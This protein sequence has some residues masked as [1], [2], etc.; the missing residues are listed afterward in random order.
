MLILDA[1]SWVACLPRDHRLADRTE[2]S[3]AELLDDPIVVRAADRRAAGATTGWRWTP[4]ATAADDRRGRRHLRGGDHDDR[5]RSRHQLHHVVGGPVLRPPGH[6]LRAD[7]RPAAAATRRWPGIPRALT[8]QADALIRHVQTH[9]SFGEGSTEHPHSADRPLINPVITRSK[10]GTSAAAPRRLSLCIDYVSY[11]VTS[12]WSD[13]DRRRTRPTHS[14]PP[15]PNDEDAKLAEF[16]YTQKLDRSVG[17]LASFAIG[18]ATISATTAVFTG[19]GAGYFTAGA[20]V[21]V[22]AAARRRGVRAL[23][24]HRRR[25]DRQDPAGRLL[26]SV[27]Q[28]DQRLDAGAGSPAFI[29]LAGW[30]CGMTGVGFI[31]SGYL[32]GLFGWNMTPDRADPRRH[33]R[34]GRLRARSTSTACGSRRW[35][36]TSASASNSSS[37]SAPPSLV[38]IIAFSAPDNHQ[39]ISVLFTGGT[40]GDKDPYILAWLAAVARPV[41]RSHRCG[42][43]RRRRRGD[44]GRPPRHSAHHVLRADRLDRHRVR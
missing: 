2:V 38:A 21:R 28:S 6:R 17:T 7:H 13:H 24:V 23:D 4:A 18:F 25:P 27:D 19:F 12:T 3:I 34:G 36:T 1:E 37:P 33:R 29:A 14:P 43:Q 35:S 31:L 32:G 11:P 44:Q 15:P 8:P 39:P 16:G 9:W 20:P 10:H 41:L 42:G 5:S 30:I 22:D 26:L 40:S